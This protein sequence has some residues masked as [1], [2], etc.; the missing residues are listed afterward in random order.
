M[1]LKM[2]QVLGEVQRGEE[3][4]SSIVPVAKGRTSMAA[5]SVD[6]WLFWCPLGISVSWRVDYR[7]VDAEF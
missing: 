7:W 3:D 4:G 2:H 6:C 1:L 5:W